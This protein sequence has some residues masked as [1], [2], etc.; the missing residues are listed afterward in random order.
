MTLVHI[1][2]YWFIYLFIHSFVCAFIH[3]YSFFHTFFSSQSNILYFLFIDDNIY[4]S[5]NKVICVILGAFFFSSLFQ[6]YGTNY[7][8]LCKIKDITCP[9]NMGPISISHS[10]S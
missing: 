1:L 4:W 8:N 2:H 9:I 7:K 5:W 6:F 10:V 3:I